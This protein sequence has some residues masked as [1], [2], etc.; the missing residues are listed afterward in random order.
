GA[1]AAL[2]AG[3]TPLELGSDIAGS[4]RIPASFCGVY[5]LKPPYGLIPLRGHIPGP[6]GT[7]A[8]A[9]LHALGPLARG[10]HDLELALDVLAG[11]RDAA[12]L[13]RH[14]ALPPARRR[15]LGESRL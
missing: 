5:G 4:I 3:W 1:G 7:L 15:S 10:V 11:P 6:P 9:D 12:P 13:A 14:L 8:P 2:A